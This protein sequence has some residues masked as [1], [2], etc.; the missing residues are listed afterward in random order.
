MLISFK[1]ALIEGSTLQTELG[2]VG[3]DTIY[4]L[5]YT[6]GTTGM[7]KGTMLKQNNFIANVGGLAMFD[8]TFK[9]S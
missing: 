8:P 6:S 7:P 4:T 3:A 9:L 2:E 5:C 1:D